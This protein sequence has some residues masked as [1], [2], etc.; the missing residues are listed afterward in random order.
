VGGLNVHSTVEAAEG[1]G[2]H[3]YSEGVNESKYRFDFRQVASGLEITLRINCLVHDVNSDYIKLVFVGEKITG[4]SG[5]YEQI[6]GIARVGYEN[7]S[8]LT[9]GYGKHL[10]YYVLPQRGF[11]SY[12]NI[13]LYSRGGS[14]TL[15]LHRSTIREW[16]P[17]THY[18]PIV[19]WKYGW[20]VYNIT[21]DGRGRI[22]LLCSGGGLP[23]GCPQESG[24]FYVFGKGFT[25]P[26]VGGR[27]DVYVDF[28]YFGGF[29]AAPESSYGKGNYRCKIDVGFGSGGTL[30]EAYYS[31][32][33]QTLYLKQKYTYETTY[34][35]IWQDTAKAE[36]DYAL[37]AGK[38]IMESPLAKSMLEGLGY[39]S[40]AY[41]VA[42]EILSLSFDE[43]VSDSKILVWEN[44]N[45]DQEK[46]LFAYFSIVCQV[47]SV[48][49]TGTIANFYGESPWGR[50]LLEGLFGARIFELPAG[51]MF[52]GGILL[53]YYVPTL[54]SVEPLGGGL[55]VNTKITM[56]FSK[57]IDRGSIV[58]RPDTIVAIAN[59]KPIDFFDFFHF[60]DSG[61]DQKTLVM[62]PNYRLDY[63]TIYVINFTS[64][65][66]DVYG[67]PLEPFTITFSTEQ[68]P[69]PPK[70]IYYN[71][72]VAVSTGLYEFGERL[73]GCIFRAEIA[74]D[75]VQYDARSLVADATFRTN[76]PLFDYW[77]EG[78]ALI[79]KVGDKAY[80][81]L[82]TAKDGG[83]PPRSRTI[84]ELVEVL[85]M[86]TDTWAEARVEEVNVGNPAVLAAFKEQAGLKP[87]AFFM[88]EPIVVKEYSAIGEKVGYITFHSD[89]IKGLDGKTLPLY[90]VI[91]SN[92]FGIIPDKPSP[93]F[94]LK[95]GPTHMPVD[96][97]AYVI[98]NGFV[99]A[100]RLTPEL[101]EQRQYTYNYIIQAKGASLEV[102]V[103]SNSTIT[104]FSYNE[105]VNAISFKASGK[106]GTRGY[107]ILAVPKS[108]GEIKPT[109]FFDY[110]QIEHKLDETENTY[111][112]RFSYSHSTHN[113]TVYL[114]GVEQSKETGPTEN[115]YTY[116]IVAA[117]PFSA[118]IFLTILYK[119][120]KRTTLPKTTFR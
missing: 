107:T 14:P 70:N 113:V 94:N 96:F 111:Y 103:F 69:P 117:A 90:A 108:F 6:M 22:S 71:V 65:I 19:V 38:V 18:V 93:V 34:P 58:K 84:F 59:S 25:P 21:D 26:K 80:V 52:V 66:V 79:F 28:N 20:A 55:P 74:K 29:N 27:P 32:L 33:N 115:N 53:H 50:P 61:S 77:N 42:Q 63:N 10:I 87:G 112:I 1:G 118:I 99:G 68:G 36:I 101:E 17:K 23:Q 114:K 76:D 95:V 62:S 37:E 78:S 40:L 97:V 81:K 104:G 4:S 57:P 102:Q 120:R 43:I 41:D 48:G 35:L 64:K 51:G 56:R 116:I 54:E 86:K 39:V 106:N 3:V 82:S 2:W 24:I 9:V 60:R 15:D 8:K 49:L 109:V 30:S 45:V 31:G 110:K 119:K 75:N 105:T 13:T 92:V 11:V 16:D 91:R 89:E 83:V 7:D 12:A 98:Q 5:T 67:F 85:E 47:K 88:L 46:E 73:R 44:V 100:W 72:S